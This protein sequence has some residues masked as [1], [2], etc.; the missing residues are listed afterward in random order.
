VGIGAWAT[1]D[2][3]PHVK[4]ICAPDDELEVTKLIG[5]VPGVKRTIA[6]R[7]GPG[8]RVF[9]VEEDM[10]PSDSMA[11]E[12]INTAYTTLESMDLEADLG[13]AD[14]GDA[15]DTSEP[16]VETKRQ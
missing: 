9:T 7:P 14:G 15:P 11:S 13:S 3:G 1:I 10:Q 4:V 12:S 6:T 16:D 2:A 5:A 8:V